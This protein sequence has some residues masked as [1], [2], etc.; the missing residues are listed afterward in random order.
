M[1]CEDSKG[2]ET[3]LTAERFPEAQIPSEAAFLQ[4]PFRFASLL[5]QLK[6]MPRKA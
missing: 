1:G 5:E 6:L 3:F 2:S 4:K